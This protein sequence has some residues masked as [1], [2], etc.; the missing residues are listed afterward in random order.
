M[1]LHTEMVVAGQL[2][3]ATGTAQAIEQGVW[4]E[5]QDLLTI[6][7]EITSDSDSDHSSMTSAVSGW[8]VDDDPITEACEV[9]S[10]SN[11][12]YSST[13]STASDGYVPPE[14][15]DASDVDATEYFESMEDYSRKLCDSAAV[16][17]QHMK[18][19]TS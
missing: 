11:F 6:A 2:L 4:M 7:D 15:S 8:I 12:H 9:I 1:C 18:G 16:A 14:V 3:L 10:E 17:L 5:D 13:T 19:I